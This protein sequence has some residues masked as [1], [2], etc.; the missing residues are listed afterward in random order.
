IEEWWHDVEEGL[1]KIFTTETINSCCYQELYS[2]IY[3]YSTVVGSSRGKEDQKLED[4]NNDKLGGKTNDHFGSTYYRNFSQ[5]INKYVEYVLKECRQYD[6][7][8]L[9]TIS[10]LS[11]ISSKAVPRKLMEYS[12]SSIDIGLSEKLTI[13][14]KMSTSFSRLLS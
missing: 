8:D 2:N 6:G 5:F 10:I 13:I 3:D 14:I 4:Q 12:P 11:G 1:V 9:L 7:E